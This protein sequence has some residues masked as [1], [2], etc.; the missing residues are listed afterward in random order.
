MSESSEE[1]VQVS[2]PPMKSYASFD[3]YAS[4]QSPENQVVIAALREF[5]GRTA[6]ELTESVKWG[7][8]CW[9]GDSRPVAYVY[10]ADGYV[11]FGFFHGATLN[12]PKRLLE[13]KAQYVRH[14][15]VRQPSDVHEKAFADLLR[16]AVSHS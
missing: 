2:M 16:Q 4:D 14:I 1:G 7:N 8:G 15:K 3:E 10:S 11:Q 13:G 5:V 9:I 12:D 6:P